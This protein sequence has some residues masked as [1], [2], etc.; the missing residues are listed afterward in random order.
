MDFCSSLFLS[1]SLFSSS[2]PSSSVLPSPLP[3]AL[4]R[5]IQDLQPSGIQAF[6]RKLKGIYSDANT[7]TITVEQLIWCLTGRVPGMSLLVF[8]VFFYTRQQYTNPLVVAAPCLKTFSEKK[9]SLES[10]T[11]FPTGGNNLVFL[12]FLPAWM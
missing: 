10:E 11:N 5:L 7:S 6:S 9:C 3:P 8:F 4:R 2:S 12:I 1:L